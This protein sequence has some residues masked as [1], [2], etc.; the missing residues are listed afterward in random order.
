MAENVQNNVIE[1]ESYRLQETAHTQTTIRDMYLLDF[2]SL[3][4]MCL[5]L[6]TYNEEED[7]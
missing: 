5:S 3:C 7:V 6:P 1:V 2:V 4:I